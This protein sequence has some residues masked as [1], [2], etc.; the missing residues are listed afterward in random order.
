MVVEVAA[1]VAARCSA[2]ARRLHPAIQTAVNN[3][4]P[5]KCP[6]VFNNVKV[7]NPSAFLGFR[8]FDVPNALQGGPFSPGTA[9]NRRLSYKPHSVSEAGIV[10]PSE[11]HRSRLF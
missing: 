9:A 6:N 5:A 11:T 3:L 10:L 4:I 2:V 7:A 8:F 1:V